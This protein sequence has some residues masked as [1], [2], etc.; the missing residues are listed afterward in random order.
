MANAAYEQALE[1]VR[2]LSPEEQQRLF[3]ELRTE[4]RQQT[5]S[6]NGGA[7][8]IH[9]RE[10]EM[11]WF[12]DKQNRAQYGGQWVALEGDQLLSHGDDLRQVFAEAKAKGVEVPFT[13][14]V[15]PLDAL[16]FGGW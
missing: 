4:R 5:Q 2:A 7:E 16:P 14:F 15:D 8:V 10:R 13:G 11:R 12:S 3:Q 1:I 9:H 6:V